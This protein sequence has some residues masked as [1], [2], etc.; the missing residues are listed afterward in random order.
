MS[1]KDVAARVKQ[2]KSK[3]L[4][5]DS[6]MLTL[7]EF[8]S[9]LIGCVPLITMDANPTN[10]K[11]W[12]TL[13]ELIEGKDP[14]TTIFQLDSEQKAEENYAFVN[15]TSGS[16]GAMKSVLTSHAYFIATMEAT[17]RTVNENT[18]PDHDVWLSP[19]S[20][21]FFINA[22]L[23]MGLNILLGIPVIFMQGHLDESSV[24]IIQ[25]YHISFV[26]ITPPLAAKLARADFSKID[27]SSVKW[28][29]TAGAPIHEKLRNAVSQQF[30]GIPLTLE[31][32]TSETMLLAI[33]IDEASRQRGSS[34]T[35]V[36]GMEARVIDT[37]TGEER[38]IGEEGEILVRNS[39][40]KF[41]GY[42]DN[43]AANK[44]FDSEGWFHTGDFGYLD[45]GS[46]VYIVDRLKELLKV[47][48]G[49]G[50]H[51]SAA[52]IESVLFEHP[53][54]SR[55]VVVGIRNQRTQIDEPTAFVE[56]KSSYT[57]SSEQGKA[58]I[59]EYAGKKL[60]GLQRLTGG[61]YILA[62]FPTTG[63][64]INHRALRQ[65]VPVH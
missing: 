56:L 22:K 13:D 52:E 12:P 32:A 43:E 64:K 21:G 46:N 24:S 63:F 23:H 7:A 26:F 11:K 18:D 14:A 5:T 1:E 49:Y 20:L 29:L 62:S 65:M 25:K 35:L 50:S 6:T 53:L 38:G 51:V 36:P 61:V 58:E 60:V 4:I 15:R 59:Q 31:W 2:S 28:V 40:A 48:E 57:G 30:G 19:L 16:T 55:V 37:Q 8:A 45:A 47:G 17:K 54:V 39:L 34:G 10:D 44:D 41:S 33:Q 3:V 42:K 27:I 9:A